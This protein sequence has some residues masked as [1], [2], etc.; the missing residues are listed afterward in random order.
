MKLEASCHCGAVRYSVDSHHPQPYMRCYC[1]IC[2]KAGGGGGYGIN[3]AADAKS[4]KVEGQEHVRVYQAMKEVDGARVKSSH[5]R[6]FCSAC[7]CHLWAFNSKWPDLLHPVA[8]SVDTPLPQPVGH[9]H[10]M[11]GS[12]APW[13]EVEAGEED[14]RF[15][16]YP[17]IS[18]AHWHEKHG[19]VVD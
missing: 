4:L 19:V 11:L 8:S 9:A 18:I 17:N 12:R 7:G 5:E 15:D 13:V 10:M 16:V 2:R 1:S 6:H 3:I 14:L